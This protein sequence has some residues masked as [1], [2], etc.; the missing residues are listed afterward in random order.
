MTWTPVSG[1]TGYVVLMEW[2]VY[3]SEVG[4]PLPVYVA[5]EVF[6]GG[7][8]SFTFSRK[9]TRVAVVAISGAGGTIGGGAKQFTALNRVGDVYP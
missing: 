9:L 8:S 2:M 7:S 1:A 4:A 6:G 5:R 3:N